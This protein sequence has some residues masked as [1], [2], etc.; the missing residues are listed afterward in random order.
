[1]KRNPQVRLKGIK[2]KYN[3]AKLEYNQ[4]D[5]ISLRGGEI[6]LQYENG[7][8]ALVSMDETMLGHY[9]MM[10]IGKQTIEVKRLNKTAS[11]TIN[12]NPIPVKQITLD[13]T[14][15]VL[16]K[17][18]TATLTAMVFPENATNK[19]VEWSS[20]NSSIARI[21]QNGK[22]TAVSPGNTV[23]E[24]KS[25]ST[26][27]VI[28]TCNLSVIVTCD[29]LSIINKTVWDDDAGEYCITLNT[30]NTLQ[31]KCDV[32]PSDATEGIIW[33][34]ENSMVAVVN[35]QGG[36]TAVGPGTTKITARSESGERD[37]IYIYVPRT[38]PTP[39]PA[40]TVPNREET[41]PDTTYDDSSYT[42][43]AKQ[44]KKPVRPGNTRVKKLKSIKKRLWV[45][46]SKAKNA[47][48]YQVIVATNK[49]FTKGLKG[50]KLTGLRG[51]CKIKRK[52]TY[53]VKVRAISSTGLVGKWSK[54]KKIKCK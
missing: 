17:G 33:Q 49:S 9:D 41:E 35:A 3:P 47:K 24:A 10:K 1:M 46:W 48:Y 51:W 50:G 29:S 28:A 30:G 23:I 6:E 36:V 11:F 32:S 39:A 15:L 13:R 27:T 43:N 52:K 45:Q 25:K 22:I 5:R 12:V 53:Y 37:S 2:V 44:S 38:I 16:K 42:H 26:G 8:T 4:G 7:K 40:P 34:S 54:A 14:Q 31:L 21:D 19:D 20:Q 18:E